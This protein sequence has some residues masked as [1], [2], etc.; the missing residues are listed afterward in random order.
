MLVSEQEPTYD[1]IAAALGMPI[2]S[3][4]PTRGRCL[5]RLQRRMAVVELDS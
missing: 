3:V 5:D 4:G 1:E 2:G